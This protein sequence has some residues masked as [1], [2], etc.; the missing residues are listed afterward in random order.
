MYR[1]QY[2]LR[3]N[4]TIKIVG[5]FSL[6]K[7]FPPGWTS[8][9]HNIMTVKCFDTDDLSCKYAADFVASWEIFHLLDLTRSDMR[10]QYVMYL[11]RG[12]KQTDCF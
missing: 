9:I 7:R 2:K 3:Q 5:F 4:N 6:V 1:E 8:F 10:Y 12:S 11:E